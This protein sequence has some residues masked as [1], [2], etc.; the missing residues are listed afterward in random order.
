M[1]YFYRYNIHIAKFFFLG[2]NKA[3]HEILDLFHDNRFTTT[4]AYGGQVNYLVPVF[5][6]MGAV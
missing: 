6:V 3:G 1:R 2:L 4:R 5:Q